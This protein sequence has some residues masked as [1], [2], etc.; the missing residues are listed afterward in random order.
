MVLKM[1]NLKEHCKHCL[2]RYGIEGIDIHKWLDEPSKKFTIGHRE[3][4]HDTETI[5]LVGKIFRKKYGRKISENIALDHIMLDHKEEI[6]KGHEKKK[7][8]SRGFTEDEKREFHLQYLVGLRRRKWGYSAQRYLT[9]KYEKYGFF[10]KL[11][12]KPTKIRM[13]Y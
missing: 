2:E 1:P 3:F 12:N 7:E 13:V 11:F 9:E 10:A 6:N 8:I 4:R 5:K